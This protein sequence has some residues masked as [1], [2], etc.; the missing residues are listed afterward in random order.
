MG[1]YDLQQ[2]LEG[3]DI[4]PDETKELKE[5]GFVR[6]NTVLSPVHNDFLHFVLFS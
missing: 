2:P 4:L 3:L 1:R 5:T 6:D